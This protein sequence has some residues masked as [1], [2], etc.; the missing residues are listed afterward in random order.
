MSDNFTLAQGY[1]IPSTNDVHEAYHIKENNI[2]CNISS[3]N[4]YTTL[5]ELINHL[6]GSLFFFMEIPSDKEDAD[7]DSKDVYYLDNC[8]TEVI[9]AILKRYGDIL[10][11]DGIVEFGFGSLD[12]NDEIYVMKYKVTSIY[13]ENIKK[14]A[15]CLDRLNFKKEDTI[16]TVWDIF[17]D[18]NTGICT[19]VECEGENLFD[20][21]EN[22]EEVGMYFSHTTN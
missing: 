22:L 7:K 12:N 11:N 15:K 19:T 2:L 10:L 18:D 4:L 20:I 21:I 1:Q 14:Y 6:S 17:S 8:T 3:E 9:L 5:N 16:I 13:S